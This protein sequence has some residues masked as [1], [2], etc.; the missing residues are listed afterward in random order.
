M[1]PEEI[2]PHTLA[3]LENP[4]DFLEEIEKIVSL[5]FREFD[6]SL[7]RQAFKDI[8]RLF[9]GTYRGYRQCNTGYHDLNHTFQCFLLMARLI[10]GAFINGFSFTQNHVVLG[11]IS[12]LMHD[13]G[14]IQ[15]EGDSTGTGGKYTTVHIE[16]S[17]EFMEGYF[18]R[19]GFS[20]EDYIFC[21]DCLKCT[22]IDVNIKEIQFESYEHEI[23]G[24]ILGTADLM[25]QMADR[26]YLR[27]LPFLYQEFV[28]AGLAMFENEVDLL[29]A[30]PDF[31]EFTKQRFSTEYGNVDRFLRD[32]FIVRWGID[33]D[34][35]R[36][37]IERNIRH[38]KF[39]LKYHLDDY[40]KYLDHE[41]IK[42]IAG[43]MSKIERTEE[44]RESPVP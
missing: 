22:G 26:D 3:Y 25:G 17:I 35:D 34:L 15:L 38:L 6:F 1:T 42:E 14:Y 16:R 30:T 19:N 18:N 13:T 9:A 20:L 23:L 21:R 24:K 31:W 28:E 40:R 10:H 7:I 32:H 29:N 36:K 44:I 39:I 4:G 27:K 33:R 8:E 2:K 41:A 5:M 37:A 11:L 12:A 43:E